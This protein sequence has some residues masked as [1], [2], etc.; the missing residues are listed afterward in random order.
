M[1]IKHKKVSTLPDDPDTT[2]ILNS[3]WN[4]EHDGEY[5]DAAAITAVPFVIE[6][7]FGSE[8]ITGQ[9]YAT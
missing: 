3:D 1:P 8:P 6:L 5:T 9:S 2:L 7:S 4:D